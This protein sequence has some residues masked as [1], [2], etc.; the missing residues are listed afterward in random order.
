MIVH[1]FITLDSSIFFILLLVEHADLFL[2]HVFSVLPSSWED[3]VEGFGQFMDS[4]ATEESA[5][6]AAFSAPIWYL[7]LQLNS[8]W[9]RGHQR[10]PSQLLPPLSP[11]PC[12]KKALSLTLLHDPAG[13][14]WGPCTLWA[15]PHSFT[16]R[17]NRE[18]GPAYQQGCKSSCHQG[19]Y[20]VLNVLVTFVFMPEGC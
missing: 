11:A 6:P 5:V 12:V 16:Q 3:E 13:C 9:V 17:T 19:E 15:P 7:F 10:P 14:S 18:C 1:G 8:P 20:V 4:V 2:L